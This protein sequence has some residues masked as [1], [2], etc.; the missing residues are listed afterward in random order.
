MRLDCVLFELEGVLVETA[1]ARRLAME[2]ALRESGCQL[3]GAAIEAAFA[4]AGDAAFDRVAEAIARHADGGMDATDTMLL[5]LRAERSFA[6]SM[7]AGATLAPG[8]ADRLRALA[9][10]GRIAVVTRAPRQVADRLLELAELET[11]MVLA[12]SDDPVPPKPSPRPYELALSRLARRGTPGTPRVVAI[13]DSPDGVAA[14]VGAGV[15]CLRIVPPG[16]TRE[17]VPAGASA[18]LPSLEAVT[19]EMLAA[20]AG[21]KLET[22]R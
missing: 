15:P 6:A 22:A 2:A 9:A 16:R 10:R 7:A 13:E 12:A 11:A 20:L 21:H 5:A 8:A 14:A 1:S 19:W 17:M 18:A 4:E 3:P